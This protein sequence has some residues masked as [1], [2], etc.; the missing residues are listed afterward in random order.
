NQLVKFL[1]LAFKAHIGSHGSQSPS[2][3]L[4]RFLRETVQHQMSDLLHIIHEG[5]H[6]DS[7]L[8]HGQV[9]NQQAVGFLVKFC[10]KGQQCKIKMIITP[11]K[12]T[13]YL[14]TISAMWLLKISTVWLLSRL[15]S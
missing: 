8:L 14:C 4:L 15:A 7:K 3:S 11:S 5:L 12:L 1:I 10:L 9:F 2:S 13:K 6:S